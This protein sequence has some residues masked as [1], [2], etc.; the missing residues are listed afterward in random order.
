MATKTIQ[1]INKEVEEKV[2]AFGRLLE[3]K[4]IPVK[5]LVVFGSYA[6]NQATINSD[7]DLCVVSSEFG[8]DPI[9][10][11]QFLVK[12]TPKI[13]TMIEPY[14][15]SPQGYNELENPLVLEIRKYGKEINRV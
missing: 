14:P 2:L 9:D 8:K 10:E 12:Q 5:K 6:K 1:Q 13:D 4:G 7:I 15:F 3:E 11:M